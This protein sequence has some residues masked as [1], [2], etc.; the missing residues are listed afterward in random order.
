[1][2]STVDKVRPLL[3]LVNG[4][5]FDRL[6]CSLIGDEMKVFSARSCKLFFILWSSWWR[7]HAVGRSRQSLMLSAFQS[8]TSRVGDL[9]VTC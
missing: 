5:A 1:M 9:G 7:F 4:F 8:L 6:S 3:G 2:V